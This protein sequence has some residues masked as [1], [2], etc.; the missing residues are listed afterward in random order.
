MKST[1]NTQKTIW[2]VDIDNETAEEMTTDDCAE[3][4][5][6]AIVVMPEVIVEVI[7][8]TKDACGDY[9]SHIALTLGDDFVAETT[10]VIEETKDS[11]GVT[12]TKTN[13]TT[14][15]MSTRMLKQNQEKP[16]W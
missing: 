14:K 7:E 4:H 12:M 9:P 1:D 3:Y 11:K 5:P 13:T 16:K 6:N 10:K 15:R 2:V 8:K